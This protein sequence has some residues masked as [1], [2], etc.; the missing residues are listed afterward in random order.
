MGIVAEYVVDELRFARTSR[1]LSQEDF[2]KLINYSASHVSSV[3]TG[4]RPPTPP[5]VAAIDEAF[6]TGGMY[7][8]MLEKLARLE[9][10]PPWLREWIEFEREADTLRWYELAYVPGLL[11]TERYA[12]ATLAGGRFTNDE[13]AQA[14]ASR[15]DRQAI[16]DR[17]DPP[18]LIVVLDVA[19]LKRPV[20][21]DRRSPVPYYSSPTP[22]SRVPATR[23]TPPAT[24][25]QISL[26][27]RVSE[28][29]TTDRKK[30]SGIR[31]GAATSRVR[32]SVL[33]PSP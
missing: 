8:R 27:G 33:V 6:K 12:R 29:R 20:P 2:G 15:L 30:P 16:L 19:V 21:P 25:S 10:A 22:S 31:I 14:V 4:Q 3:E 26:F 32:I 23:L 1:D 28:G 9:I 17:D 24:T 5:Y 7:T 11:Q 13:I 18:Q